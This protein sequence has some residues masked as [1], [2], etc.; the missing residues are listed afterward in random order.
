MQLSTSKQLSNPA[1]QAL[2]QQNI[3]K[4]TANFEKDSKD[5]KAWPVL[6]LGVSY[7]F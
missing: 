5:L 2:L 4:E 3:D 7:L 6:A 1:A